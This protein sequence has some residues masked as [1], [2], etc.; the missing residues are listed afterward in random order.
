M[1]TS[2]D[3]TSGLRRPDDIRTDYGH[4]RV[5]SDGGIAQGDIPLADDRDGDGIDTLAPFRVS[6]GE[7]ITRANNDPAWSPA[8]H[9]LEPGVP[10]RAPVF[11]GDW[12]GDGTDSIGYH[13]AG[14]SRYSN[15]LGAPKE[16]SHV[17]GNNH[18]PVTG[19]W[20]LS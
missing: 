1:R 10:S 6:S 19:A 5:T 15:S 16:L 7:L 11:A 12:D 17:W 3:R 18:N 13:L 8:T 2:P 4:P 9:H 20:A 14:V